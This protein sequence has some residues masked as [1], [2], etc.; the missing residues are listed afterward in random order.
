MRISFVHTYPS[1]TSEFLQ[2]TDI[3]V[4]EVRDPH[5]TPWCH[6]HTLNAETAKQIEKQLGWQKV[7]TE[8]E[9]ITFLAY[10]SGTGVLR[11]LSR[12]FLGMEL[13]EPPLT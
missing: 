5:G 10:Y 1:I 12:I 13:D 2:G 4:F 11:K 9:K 3:V 6:I 7:G 8:S